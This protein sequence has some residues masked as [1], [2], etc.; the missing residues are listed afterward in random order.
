MRPR[1][2]GFS[3]LVGRYSNAVEIEKKKKDPTDVGE[4]SKR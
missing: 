4:R 3:K 2:R 1:H